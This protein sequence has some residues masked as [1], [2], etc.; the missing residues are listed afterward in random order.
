MYYSSIRQFCDGKIEVILSVDHNVS[1]IT[2][3]IKYYYN[4]KK[5]I[6]LLFMENDLNNNHPYFSSFIIINEY[7]LIIDHRYAIKSSH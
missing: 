1:I 4:L 3:S 7:K 6:I 2:I 5:R